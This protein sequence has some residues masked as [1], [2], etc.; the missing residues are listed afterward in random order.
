MVTIDGGVAFVTGVR[1]QGVASRC[2]SRTPCLARRVSHAVSRT[3]CLARRVSHV[4]SRTPWHMVT[5][6]GGVGFVTG[7]R[8]QGV[9]GTGRESESQSERCTE[10]TPT[11][12]AT[13]AFRDALLALPHRVTFVLPNVLPLCYLCVTK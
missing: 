11:R 5:I 4:V 7:V 6:D 12:N 2:L 9:A 13:L 3:P 1:V 10:R 8:V